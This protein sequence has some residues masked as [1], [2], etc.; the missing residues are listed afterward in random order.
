MIE[1]KRFAVDIG[2]TLSTQLINACLS[3]LAIIGA[4]FVFI[5]DKR[6]TFI[7]FYLLNIFGFISLI[8][9]IFL[10]GKGIDKIRKNSFNNQLN[11]DS[12]KNYFNWQAIL[13][14]GGILFCLGSLFFTQKV[15]AENKELIL[16]NKTLNK[17]NQ[18]KNEN[19]TKTDSLIKEVELLNNR[20]KKLEIS[21]KK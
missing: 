2:I 8:I 15:K 17:L 11:L 20:L 14:L 3:I 19:L 6:E 18:I 10:G 13:C 9:S 1:N 5:I 7:P 16:I 21:Q 12:T 4:V